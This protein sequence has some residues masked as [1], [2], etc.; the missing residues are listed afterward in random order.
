MQNSDSLS[1]D[2]SLLI[3]SLFDNVSEPTPTSS[4]SA[5]LGSLTDILN[6]GTY[7]SGYTRIQAIKVILNCL[8]LQHRRLRLAK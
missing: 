7:A 5:L 4:A 2:T 8:K 3:G 1:V 6:T